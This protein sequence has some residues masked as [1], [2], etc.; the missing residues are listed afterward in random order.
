MAFPN[1]WIN[2][3]RYDEAVLDPGLLFIN[4]SIE[5]SLISA[6][7]KCIPVGCVPSAR[8]CVCLGGRGRCLPG[9][10]LSKGGVCSGGVCP[11]YLPRGN[12]CLGGLPKRVVHFPPVD[13]ILDTHLWKHYLFAT[14]FVDGKKITFYKDYSNLPPPVWKTKMLPQHQ[15]D[16]GNREDI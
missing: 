10:C 2:G 3:K 13:R 9:G 15:Q 4:V 8:D 7:K 6:R 1:R 16:S 14:S 5:F 11:G 12:I